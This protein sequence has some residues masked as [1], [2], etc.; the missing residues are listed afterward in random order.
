[1]NKKIVVIVGPTASGKTSLSIK[2]A[3]QFNG[4]V[5]SADSRQV[6]RGMDLGSGKVTQD[7]MAGIPHHLLD[8]ADPMDVYTAS[9]FVR[10]AT[11]SI[12]DIVKRG[13]LPI[14]AGGTFFYV[15]SLLNRYSLPEV[16]PNPKLR[17]ELETKTTDELFSVLEKKDPNRAKT[18]DKHNSRRL[19]RSLEIIDAL[20]LVPKPTRNDSSYNACLFGVDIK[21]ETLRQNIHNRILERLDQGMVK[22]VENLIKKGVT[23][24]RL[25]DLGLEYRFISRYLR[26]KISYDEMIIQLDTKICQFAKRQMTWLKR[27]TD[28]IWIDPKDTENIFT[29]TQKFL[30]D[31]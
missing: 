16:P 5:I 3:K 24:E 14:V 10:D 31:E 4:E 17:S 8:V 23:H 7:E 26:K 12:D 25:E 27:D 18:I 22:E 28:I 11:A 21:Q 20:G 13:N 2:I 9:D 15:D 19:I 29:T 30:A 1:M 6:Y